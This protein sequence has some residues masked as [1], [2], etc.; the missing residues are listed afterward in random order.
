MSSQQTGCFTP[1]TILLHFLKFK[2]A[3]LTK[4]KII[5]KSLSQSIFGHFIDS[6]LLHKNI[7][8]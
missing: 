3:D 2:T 6:H 7:K 1:N 8:Y 5:N 4:L